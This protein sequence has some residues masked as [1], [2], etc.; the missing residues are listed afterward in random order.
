MK[1][2]FAEMGVGNGSFFSTEI[3]EGANEYRV[4]KFIRPDKIDG[5]YLRFWI[6]KT[7]FVLSTNHGFEM[8]KKDKNKLK[9]LLGVGGIINP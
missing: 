5:Y 2:V 6:F 7:V 3:E 1:K 4:P 8:K 9:I